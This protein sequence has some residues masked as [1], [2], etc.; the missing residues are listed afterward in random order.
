MAAPDVQ[1]LDPSPGTDDGHANGEGPRT[2]NLVPL[3][4]RL[5][6]TVAV[7]ARRRVLGTGFLTPTKCPVAAKC[8]IWDRDL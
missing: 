7:V 8:S 3:P 2:L 1:P 4:A 6:T 5:A